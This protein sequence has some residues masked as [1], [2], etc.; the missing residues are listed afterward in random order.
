MKKQALRRN[1]DA[2]SL[3]RIRDH[4]RK[5]VATAREKVRDMEQRQFQ[6]RRH[7]DCLQ[8]SVQKFHLS[9]A[10]GP[11]YVCCVCHQLWFQESVTLVSD[12]TL[13]KRLLESQ[14]WSD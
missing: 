10:E 13:P 7:G 1:Q 2:H 3:E 6:E 11:I 9:I 12:K 5:K 8:T 4:K 14:L